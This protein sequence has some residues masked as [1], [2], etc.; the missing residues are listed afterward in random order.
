MNVDGSYF[1]GTILGFLGV[2]LGTA[3]FALCT[4][5]LGLPWSL[6]WWERWVTSHTVIQGHRLRFLGTGG[7]LFW[8]WIKLEF[9]TIITIGI[10]GLWAWRYIQRWKVEHTEFVG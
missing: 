7:G 2:R 4:L 5:G 9:F 8:R 1:D 3:L 10:Y 6:V